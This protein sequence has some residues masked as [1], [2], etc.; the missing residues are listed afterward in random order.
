ML[1]ASYHPPSQVDEQFFG[2]V[3]IFRQTYTKLLLICDFNAEEPE[4]VQA[5]CLHD[6][7]AVNIIH[8]NTCYKSMNS[9]SCTNFIITL[10]VII[11][12]KIHK[13]STQG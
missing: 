3:G 8:E 1:F 6:Y 12:L 2:E 9:L 11:V 7:N 10:T 13:L 5:R 4:P